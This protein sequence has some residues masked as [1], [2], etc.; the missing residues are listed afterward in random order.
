MRILRP[1]FVY[2]RPLITC[3][4]GAAVI[5]VPLIAV[6]NILVASVSVVDKNG[7]H[8]SSIGTTKQSPEDAIGHKI[9]ELSERIKHAEMLAFERKREILQLRSQIEFM[10]QQRS[11]GSYN[12]VSHNHHITNE[13]L[14]I[15][16]LTSFLP[17]LLDHPDPL[18]PAFRRISSKSPRTSATIV[19]GLPTVRRP[20]ESY[21]LSTLENLIENLSPA[22]KLEAVIVI[23]I[24]EVRSL[25][26]SLFV[27]TFMLLCLEHVI[28]SGRQK[29]TIA[30]ELRRK[31]RDVNQSVSLMAGRLVIY[32]S[33]CASGQLRPNV[34]STRLQVN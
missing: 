27:H 28:V 16:A 10:D 17:H 3:L 12:N 26:I 4:V 23:S 33:N 2:G 32:G 15:P 7:H 20:V 5:L 13:L 25:V 29:K 19:F 24:F 31:L 8:S 21:L 18:R 34:H 11:L 1:S 6:A 14:Q 9:I 22:E 30:H